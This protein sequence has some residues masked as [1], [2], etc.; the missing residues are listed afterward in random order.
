MSRKIAWL[1][2]LLACAAFWQCTNDPVSSRVAPRALNPAEKTLAG[3]SNDFGLKLF[4]AITTASPQS[5]V[6]ISPL[7][8]SLALGM[9]YNGAG[10]TT[11]EA[12]Q[13][14]L[15]L[16]GLTIE[17][18]NQSYTSLIELLGGMDPLV[19]FQIANSIWYRQN[20]T[21]ENK[22][23][24]VNKTYFNAEVTGLNFD[25]PAASKTIND[26]VNKST[27]GKITKIVDDQID[28]LTVMFLIN[29]MYFKGTWTT[30][31]NKQ[32]TRDDWFYPAPGDSASCKMMARADTFVYFEND[33]FQAVDLPYGNGDFSMTVLLPRPGVA[34]DSLA[35][36][37]SLKNW[38]Q[39]TKS[40]AQSAGKLL[41]PKFKLEYDRLLNDDLTALGMGVAF[42]PGNADFTEINQIVKLY[43]SKVK[44][45][46]Y[47]DVDE[48]GTEAA[49]VTSVEIGLTSIGGGSSSFVMRVDRPFVFVI[50][51]HHSGTLLF[52]GRVV[53]PAGI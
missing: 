28:P 50:R 33:L 23:L 19:K 9:A 32:S 13:K 48:E 36:Q 30:E 38:E 37:F 47:V 51:E 40:F 29:A 49:A 45:K 14:T 4:H 31:F 52:M 39:W 5:N 42:E 17:E 26:W 11:R 8:V 3:S 41:L 27:K 44:H 2:I 16:S 7:S 53:R 12:M 43:I 21:V 34:V 6:F 35:A 46:T 24:E 1:I 10:G 20:F 15:E 22:F 18:A 25:D